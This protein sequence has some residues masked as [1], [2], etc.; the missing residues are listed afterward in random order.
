[1]RDP[2]PPKLKPMG[3]LLLLDDDADADEAVREEP[4]LA[5]SRRSLTA[6][7]WASNLLMMRKVMVSELRG[8]LM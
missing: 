5:A 1:M 8:L 2:A 6:V 4:Y 3:L 7:S